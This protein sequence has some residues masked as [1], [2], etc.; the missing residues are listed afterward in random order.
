MDPAR[1]DTFV[2]C[3]DPGAVL[4][5]TAGFL[6]LRAAGANAPG[7]YGVRDKVLE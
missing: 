2:I 6:V 4:L 5:N 3:D 1:T 7:M